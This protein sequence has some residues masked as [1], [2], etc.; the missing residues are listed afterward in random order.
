MKEHQE[1]FYGFIMG[2]VEE[3]H[4]EEADKL[5]KESFEKQDNGT[6]NLEFL[7]QFETAMAGYLKPEK[8]E[9]VLKVMSQFKQQ[10]QR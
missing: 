7:Q 2:S 1:K 6:F 8:K 4:K 3:S 5:L 9:E 10:F